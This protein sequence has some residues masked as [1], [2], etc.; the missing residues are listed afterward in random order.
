MEAIILQLFTA[1]Y[2]EPQSLEYPLGKMLREKYKDLPWIPIESH[3]R[4]EE[5][6][7]KRTAIFLK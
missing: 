2:Y 6:T 7:K 1:V 4:I 3:N 5:M